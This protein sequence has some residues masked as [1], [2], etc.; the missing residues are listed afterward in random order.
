M[1]MRMMCDHFIPP[2]SGLG[3]PGIDHLR[4]IA[5]YAL[6]MRPDVI[7]QIGDWASFDSVSRHDAPG[8][9][10]QKMRQIGRA[11]CRERVSS[12]V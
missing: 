11:S 12:P 3:S 9:I 10:K 2:A 4:W 1:A 8:S 5:N 7:V 6:E